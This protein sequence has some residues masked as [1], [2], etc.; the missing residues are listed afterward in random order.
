MAPKRNA[1]AKNSAFLDLPPSEAPFTQAMLTMLL[2]QQSTPP[3]Q[4]DPQLQAGIVLT[5][6][7]PTLWQLVGAGVAWPTPPPALLAQAPLDPTSLLA[8]SDVLEPVCV[9]TISVKEKICEKRLP[10]TRLH[11]Q[12][13]ICEATW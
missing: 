13:Q 5:D 2:I 9:E 8:V 6:H 11:L 10:K 4:R 1:A 7:D 12:D 3:S